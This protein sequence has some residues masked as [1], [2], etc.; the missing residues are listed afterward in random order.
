MSSFN[1]GAALANSASNKKRNFGFLQK[2]R[3]ELP[4]AIKTVANSRGLV[5]LPENYKPDDYAI[6]CGRG[7][8]NY[9]CEG[10]ILFRQIVAQYVD[11]YLQSESKAAK[12]LVLVQVLE[13]VKHDSRGKCRF[14]KQRPEDG[15]WCELGEVAAREKAGHAMRECIAT[16]KKLNTSKR[17]AMDGETYGGSTNSHNS[18]TNSN[19]NSK[20]LPN[21]S[22]SS[23]SSGL[24]MNMNNNNNNGS[25]HGKNNHNLAMPPP[26]YSSDTAG[27]VRSSI[28]DSNNNSNNAAMKKKHASTA[29]PSEVDAAIARLSLKEGDDPFTSE[30]MRVIEREMATEA[31]KQGNAT[32]NTKTK[33]DREA[34]VKSDQVFGKPVAALPTND[35]FR[36]GDSVL[37]AVGSSDFLACRSSEFLKKYGS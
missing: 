3:V 35:K 31:L 10:N 8:G 26:A 11:Q 32:T 6:V 33:R 7:R 2:Y 25:H 13:Q 4:E 36:E 30:D 24:M 27:M 23:S 18:S 12:T 20:V 9:N 28:T 22:T 17:R 37:S 19:N 16:R 15:L 1:E 34:S 21:T 14:V 5:P 29:T